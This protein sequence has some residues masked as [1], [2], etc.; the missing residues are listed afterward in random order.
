MDANLLSLKTHLQ[1]YRKLDEEMKALNAKIQDLRRDRKEV[2]SEMSHILALPEFIQYDKLE[3]K[4]DGSIVKIQR[5]GMWTKPWS[6][7]KNELMDSL[8]LYFSTRES[9]ASA[10][11]C[12]EFLV[13]RQKP[14]MA[15]NE[16]AFDRSPAPTNKKMKILK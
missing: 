5:P 1:T 3:I 8:D 11:G 16:F 6:L 4:D 2:E 7:S 15:A 13:D 10:E 14:K 12:Y 9:S